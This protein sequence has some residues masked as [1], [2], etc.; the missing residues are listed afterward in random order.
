VARGSAG[1]QVGRRYG[2]LG[3]FGN[4]DFDRT[5]RG[6]HGIDK[7]RYAQL[8]PGIEYLTPSGALRASLSGG[9]S[10]LTS[11]VNGEPIGTR[12]WYFEARP[13]AVRGN[14]AGHTLELTP[15]AIE[16]TR[17]LTHDSESIFDNY[18]KVSYEW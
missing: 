9:L 6:S 5:L 13:L 14:F 2:S 12:G 4:L 15:F 8:G 17:P 3:F 7:I 18:L 11:E 16:V 1:V 10:I